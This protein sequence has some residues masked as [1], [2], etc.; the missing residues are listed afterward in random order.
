MSKLTQIEKALH[1]MDAAGFQRLCDSYLYK[2]GYEPIN[3]LGLVIGADKVAKGTPDNLVTRSDGTYDFAEYSTQQDGLA[4]KF[5]S[6]LASCFDE[7]KTGIPTNRIHEIVLCHNARMTPEEQHDLTEQCRG[8]GILLSIYGLGAIAHDLYQKYPGMAKDFLGVDVDTRQILSAPDFIA[9]YNKRSFATPLDTAFKF[10]DEELKQVLEAFEEKGLALV[11]GRPGVGKTRFALECCELYLKVHRDAQ[12]YC[13]FNKGADL[14]EDLRVHFS[15]PG[16]FLILVDDA[17]RLSRFEYALQ[18]LHD[19]R[20]DQKIRIIAT[21]RDYA[22]PSIQKAAHPY[23]DGA[24]IELEQFKEDQIKELVRHNSAITNI[25]YLDRIAEI[26]QG[27]PRLAMMAARVAERENNLQSIADVSALYDEYFASIRD[28]LEDLGNSTHILVAGIIAFFRVIDRSNAEMMGAITDNFQID[29]Q[30]FWQAAERLHTLEVVDLYEKEIVRISDQV[31]S[32]YLFYLAAF[33]ERALEFGILL[34]HFFPN[35]RHRLI[36][37]LNPVLSAFSGDAIVNALRPDVDRACERSRQRGDEDRLMNLLD[38]FW[39]VKP[40]DTLVYLQEKIEAM[41]PAPVPLSELTYVMS[42]NLPPSPSVLGILDNFRYAD[43]ASMNSALSLM[44][45]YLEKRPAELPLVLRMLQERYGMDHYSYLNGFAIERATVDAVWSRAQGGKDEFFSRLLLTI[46]EP[47]LHTHFQTSQ[48]KGNLSIAIINF[49]PPVSKA[50]LDFRKELWQRI[51]SLYPSPVL[52]EE[53]LNVI[54]KH[55][56]SGYL[57]ANQEI[58]ASDSEQVLAFFQSSLDP[59][60]YRHC[61]LVHAYLDVLERVGVDVQGGLGDRFI[62]ETY[63]LSELVLVNRRER[64]DVG[65]EEYQTMQRERLT[66]H[67]ANF[68]ESEFARFFERCA[69]ITRTADGRQYEYQVQSSVVNALLDLAERDTSLFAIVF[70]NY[71]RAGNLLNLGPWAL[72]Q[73]LIQVCG[74]KRAY[75]ILYSAHYRQRVSWLFGY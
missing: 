14:F 6:D 43:Q 30:E 63:K 10:R 25:L 2:R 48:S 47:L 4:K 46:A 34:E 41:E 33:R 72:A 26:A 64:R 15:E 7:K 22:L 37:A 5:A 73:K 74:S 53:V 21:V 27:N 29:A 23:G 44:L 65:W 9:A 38:V 62:N 67:T 39:F 13:I 57:V 17:N 49:D 20:Q 16:H 36:D 12:V 58:I 59:T 42:H 75:E 28:D 50:L 24:L 52:R 35:F 8:Q 56:A 54:G 31:L 71:L 68:D 60:I 32:T 19:Q 61:V 55:S 70:E 18:L 11:S 69:E 66:A 1:S 40:T 45:N 51:F 3:T